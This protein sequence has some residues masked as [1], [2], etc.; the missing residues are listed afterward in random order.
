MEVKKI[1]PGIVALAMLW[2]SQA[3]AQLPV[4]EKSYDISRKAKNGFLGGIEVDTAKGTF[5]MIYVLRSSDRKI[6]REIYTFDKELNLVNTVK[7]EEEVEKMRHKY[8][9]FN[10]KGDT[11]V[12]HSLTASANLT[13]KL[14][15][16]KKE[17]TWKYLW[18]TGSYSKSVKQLEKV[19]PTS[20][21][22][23]QYIFRGGAYEVK[24][25]ST[26]LIV[27]GKQEKKNDLAGS[28]MHYQILSC[29]NDVN[30]KSLGSID[31]EYANA[32]I[33]SAPLEDDN[34]ELDNDDNPRDWVLVFAPQ[35]GS[36]LGSVSDPKPTNYTYVRLNTKGE[37]LERFNFQ[38]PSN[39]WRVL[40]AYD[41]DGSV[42]MYGSAN[43]KNEGKYINQIYKTTMVPTT[44][45]DDKEQEESSSGSGGFAALKSGISMIGGT[46]DFGITQSK[47]DVIL[48]ELKYTNFQIGKI[49]NGKFDFLSSPAVDEFDQKKTK[50]VN[51]KKYVEFDGKSFVINGISFSHSGDIFV[52]GQDFKKV[53]GKRSYKGVYMFQFSPT[54]ELK[55]NYGVFLDQ[56]KTSGFFNNS[57]LTSDNI[58]SRSF[59][60][61]SADGKN[62]YWMMRMAK[63]IHKE[64]HTTFGGFSNTITTVWSPLYSM[65][66]GSIDIVNNQL[67]DFNTLGDSERRK[68]YLYPNIN[69]TVL[70]NYN[71]FFSETERGDKVLISRVDLSK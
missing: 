33:F 50:P 71:L 53:K 40:G 7:D 44:S 55:R 51:Q 56:S 59:M 57:P 17:I 5:D 15:F 63:S 21:N 36:G 11:R 34:A 9:W 10:F 22:S 69:A 12:T 49:S 67:S 65:E 46:A 23:E 29:D 35:G 39:G 68:F 70:D 20:D 25:D 37:V 24:S 52:N 6:K 31:F 64:S 1:L 16:R 32:P 48:D 62:L 42:F 45:A 58:A 18:L 61:E 28:M 26:V 30:I 66:Y 19:K 47:I 38:S 41:H 54:G 4:L 13:Q 60:Q 14:V 3:Y 8:K 2:A 43:N 27:A